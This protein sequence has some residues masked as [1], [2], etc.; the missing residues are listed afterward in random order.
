MSVDGPAHAPHGGAFFEAIGTT[1]EDLG[2]SEEVVNAD[3]LD[4]WYDPAPVV[5]EALR[6][7]LEWLVKTSPPTL[8]EGL[9]EVIA[10]ERSVAPRSLTVGSG[11]SALMYLAL[12]SL[13]RPGARILL[14]D[15][16]YGEYRHMFESVLGCELSSHELGLTDGFPFDPHLLAAQAET[17]DLVVVVAPNSP[18]GNDMSQAVEVVLAN[19][20]PSCKVWIDET[21][22]DF[23]GLPSFEERV[24]Q[25]PRIIVS[26]SMSKYYAL[27]GL[28]IGYL[29][30]DPELAA[31]LAPFSPPWSVGLLAQ[32]A[33]VKALQDGRTYY[34]SRALETHALRN[35]LRSA[36]QQVTGIGHV[37]DGIANFLLFRLSD[38]SASRVVAECVQQG[39]FLRDCSSISRRFEDRYIRTAVK[40]KRDNERIVA[41]LSSVL[42]GP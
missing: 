19:A 7:H 20:R 10:S 14:F 17:A 4:A 13:V 42:S 40:E 12:P 25:D 30:S 38:T 39:V 33:A 34:E 23:T 6:G 41:A 36:L 32:V 8:G 28:R 21:Y 5:L 29:V 27:S 1:F 24:T 18:T 22:V 16:S 31:K 3:V 9:I 2:R 37:H 35:D 26:K 15:P 11:T